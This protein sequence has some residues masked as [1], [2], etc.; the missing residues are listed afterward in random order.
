VKEKAGMDV[1]WILSSAVVL[2][3]VA[4][5]MKTRRAA[6][7]NLGFVSRDWVVRHGTD[8]TGV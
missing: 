5:V 1:L 7:R 2:S 3:I 8:H 4:A 6:P